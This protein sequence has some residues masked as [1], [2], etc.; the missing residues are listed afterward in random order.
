MRIAL[1]LAF[2]VSA[3][4]VFRGTVPSPE[5]RAARLNPP[6]AM[7]SRGEPSYEDTT[8]WLLSHTQANARASGSGAGM[9]LV[10]TSEISDS[11]WPCVLLYRRRT[12]RLDAGRSVESLRLLSLV[13]ILP[14]QMSLSENGKC[15]RMVGSDRFALALDE[16]GAPDSSS[17]SET[18]CLNSEDNAGRT[19]K[20]L[21]H[22]S[23]L[24]GASA[25]AA[26]F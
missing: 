8:R 9:T 15:V 1:G 16:N 21:Q 11:R 13:E 4:G 19:M 26:P 24:C 6:S 5:E 22:A 7:P 17:P 18:V 23:E 2:L 12:A 14:A 25:A 20:A 3:C 10:A